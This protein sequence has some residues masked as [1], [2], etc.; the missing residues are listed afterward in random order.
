MFDNNVIQLIIKKT[1]KSIN[2]KL[3][4]LHTIRTETKRRFWKQKFACSHL[5]LGRRWAKKI[6]DPNKDDSTMTPINGVVSMITSETRMKNDFK[7]E[8]H[9]QTATF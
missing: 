9:E 7:E 1:D 4:K 2:A 3:L 8:V 5:D 6:R